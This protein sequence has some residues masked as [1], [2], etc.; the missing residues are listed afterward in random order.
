MALK[1]SHVSQHEL[2]IMRGKTIDEISHSQIVFM[3]GITN[4]CSHGKEA[5]WFYSEGK[6]GTENEENV[7]DS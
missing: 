7:C 3:G 2:Y 6:R 1:E 4:K 5:E